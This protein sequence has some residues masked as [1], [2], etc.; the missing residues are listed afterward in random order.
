MG[1]KSSEKDTP[2]PSESLS[3]CREECLSLQRELDIFRN[4]VL[5]AEHV[6][7][8]TDKNGIIEFVNPSFER[9]TGYTAAE[10][11]GS[12]PNLLKS[13]CMPDVYYRTLWKTILAG[14]PWTEEVVNRKKSGDL[15]YAF[16]IITPVLDER[17]EITH[18]TAIQNDFTERKQL[19]ESLEHSRL[20]LQLALEGTGAGLWDWNITEGS[21]YLSEGWQRL[22]GYEPG[23]I[24]PSIQERQQLIHPDE[25]ESV[26]QLI[27]DHL[28]GT[29][30]RYRS[31]HR[32]LRK[33]GTWCWVHDSGK[34]TGRDRNG[35]PVRMTGTHVDITQRKLWEAE[36]ERLSVTDPLTGLYNRAKFMDE[37]RR[38][39]QQVNRYGTP[40]GLIMFDIDHFKQIN[41]TRGHDAG[42]AVL[43]DL[44]FLVN[45]II[46]DTDT[47]SRW[48]GE[49][50]MIL[51]SMTDKSGTLQLAERI[52]SITAQHAFSA[53]PQVTV[54][55]GVTSMCARD[56]EEQLLKRADDAL[57]RA[58]HNGR[59]RVDMIMPDTV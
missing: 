8:I 27:D 35:T 54:S 25:R 38:E 2:S 10:A 28:S 55:C 50:F 24:T 6:F 44:T 14:K 23:E 22:L 56:S 26:K 16:Q 20:R 42:D 52:C 51:C 12:T 59:N 41:D 31:E 37:L 7:Y 30:D 34:V 47:F 53:V 58:K 19:E 5:Q 11:L 3:E 39:T 13:G 32:L 9:I 17:G 36:L 46:R 43:K 29:T 4:A 1:K 18:F 45:E 40:A 21:L 15:Y 48:G 49:E 57:Y 33:D